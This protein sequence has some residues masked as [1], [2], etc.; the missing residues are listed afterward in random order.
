M[1]ENETD[2][3]IDLSVK[4]A[5]IELKNP[6]LT[7]SGTVGYGPEYM[8][9]CDLSQLGAFT[10]KSITL[11][12]REG[13]PPPRTIETRAGLINSIGLANVGI[14]AFIETKLPEARQPGIPIFVNVAG[15]SIDEYCKVAETLDKCQ[16]ISA[17]ELNI[18]CPNVSE[19]GIE[20]GTDPKLA[21]KLVR[22]VRQ[23]VSEKKLIVK[24]SPNVT[25][26]AEIANSV[27]EAGADILSMI[28]TLRGMA[29][30]VETHKPYIA[31]GFGGL[32][33]PAIKPVAVFC[34]WSVYNKVARAKNIPIIG[35]GGV[36]F[37]KD[38]IELMLAGASAVAVGTAMYID[39]QTPMK[40]I[41]G[42]REYCIRH[43]VR[44]IS[45]IVG[46]VINPAMK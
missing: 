37:A 4:L 28:N 12:K 22:N 7:A 11:E 18:S 15:K 40:I 10:T 32:S 3:K 39:P 19:G 17:L 41:K 23:S 16:G 25:D 5:G 20:F 13:N 21:E 14:E 42:I 31:R 29:I 44:K 45:D 33:G 26:I 9:Y 27:V 1:N 2:N 6:I 24:L 34:I 38:A 43:K 30:D 46:S 8:N 36:Q 35:M